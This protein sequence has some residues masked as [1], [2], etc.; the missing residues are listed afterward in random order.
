MAKRGVFPKLIPLCFDLSFVCDAFPLELRFMTNFL[1]SKRRIL[2][3][4]VPKNAK[5]GLKNVAIG[6]LQEEHGEPV[7]SGV[8]FLHAKRT[9]CEESSSISSCSPLF[10]VALKAV[11]VGHRE[12][13]FFLR[14]FRTT[15][16]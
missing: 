4:F 15:W 3:L 1:T 16:F 2:R 12:F 11:G 10:E 14:S 13:F 9:P 8:G 7:C 5:R 6:L